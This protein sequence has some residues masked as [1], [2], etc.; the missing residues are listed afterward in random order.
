MENKDELCSSWLKCVATALFLEDK[1]KEDVILANKPI[2]KHIEKFGSKGINETYCKEW[3]LKTYN[4]NHPLRFGVE[5]LDSIEPIR[6]YL[7][8][9]SFQNLLKQKPDF[10]WVEV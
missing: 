1:F 5:T 4:V 6:V 3:F 2:Y 8:D 7:K 9:K 10:T